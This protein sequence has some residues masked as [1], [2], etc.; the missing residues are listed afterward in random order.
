MNKKNVYPIKYVK[1]IK[2]RDGT[3]VTLRPIKKDDELMMMEL[4]KTF[5]LETVRYRFF[6]P[7]RR[8][9]HEDLMR[10]CNVDYNNEIAIV[11]EIMEN[12]RRHLIGVI[13][14]IGDKDKK[15]RAEFAVVVGDPWQGK[16]LG[17]KLLDFIVELSRDIQISEIHGRV[18][19]DNTKSLLLYKRLGFSRTDLGIE[20]LVSK[21]L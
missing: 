20:Y 9:T 16:G 12:K 11:A 21:K 19:K 10:Y 1:N 8:M 15:D 17:S 14:L 6:L 18:M 4:F 7:L 13:R 3:K 5:S 2:L